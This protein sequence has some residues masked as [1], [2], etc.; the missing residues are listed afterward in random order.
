MICGLHADIID[1]PL[2]GDLVVVRLQDIMNVLNCVIK[3]AH[4]ILMMDI[5]KSND[6]FIT[7][8]KVNCEGLA[9]AS[10]NRFSRL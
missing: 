7:L 6:F 5:A 10:W 1:E 9:R 2:A 4:M 8:R 3:I